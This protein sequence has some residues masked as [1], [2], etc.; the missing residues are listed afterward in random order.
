M[1][2]ILKFLL[3]YCICV[4][5]FSQNTSVVGIIEDVVESNK[6]SNARIAIKNTSIEQVS[7]MEGSFTIALNE[8]VKGNHVLMISK[9][10]YEIRE[11]DIYIVQ[12]KRL[13]LE[14]IGL[15]I[16]NKERKN[17]NTERKSNGEMPIA[18]SWFKKKEVANDVEFIYEDVPNPIINKEVPK[19]AVNEEVPK[20]VVE[21][22]IV[23]KPPKII[24]TPLQLKYADLIGVPPER[25]TNLKLYEFIDEW[26][27]TPYQL[28]GNNK[29]GID[30][31]SFTLTLF[32]KVYGQYNIGRTAK[33]QL[34]EAKNRNRAFGNPEYLEEGDLVFFGYP[35][36]ENYNI[37]H[38]GVYLANNKFI[39]STSRRGPTGKSGV[40]ISDLKEVYWQRRF[41]AWGRW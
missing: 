32:G 39:N 4:N 33:Q 8:E 6:V 12:G 23:S 7:D 10:G 14:N 3:F 1:K 16:T 38:V 26:M 24:Y 2:I 40:K 41:R 29:N 25:I 30:C 31:S 22:E 28:G 15:L 20:P 27:Q 9:P 11:L 35:G 5:S 36:E 18:K 17:R 37:I 19:P 34:L 21:K 13:K